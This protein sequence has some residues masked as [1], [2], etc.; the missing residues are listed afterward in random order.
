MKINKRLSLS[1]LVILGLC[2]SYQVFADAAPARPPY[3]NIGLKVQVGLGSMADRFV[4]VNKHSRYGVSYS[5]VTDPYVSPGGYGA[6]TYFA[7][8]Q[9]YLQSNGG[10]DNLFNVVGQD[11]DVEE[12][13]KNESEFNSHK[14]DFIIAKNDPLLS[15]QFGDNQNEVV[16][17][18]YVLFPFTSDFYIRQGIDDP[19]CDTGY[20]NGTEDCSLGTKT[21]TYLPQQI[22]GNKILLVKTSESSNPVQQPAITA[23]TP[24]ST[25]PTII[26]ENNQTNTPSMATAPIIPPLHVPWYIRFWNFLKSLF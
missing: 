15:N 21:L 18:Q 6:D 11:E 2:F 24:S 17:G 3:L 9:S 22:Y 4:L 12:I 23:P 13:P 14:Y 1:V 7:L 5:L 20:S 10:L 16:N 8:E 25:T 19:N 26:N